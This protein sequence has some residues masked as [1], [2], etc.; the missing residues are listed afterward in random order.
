MLTTAPPHPRIA[1]KLDAYRRDVHVRR[2]LREF[3]GA[4]GED[5]PTARY[6]AVLRGTERPPVLWRRAAQVPAE[7]IDEVVAEGDV[8]RS[9]WDRESLVFLLDLDYQNVDHP[10]EPFTAPADVFLKLEPTYISVLRVFALYGL[11]AQVSMTGRGY[12]FVGRVPIDDLLVDRLAALLPEPPPWFA[13]HAL[14][15]AITARTARASAGLGVLTEFLAQEILAV[16]ERRSPIPVVLN[17]TVVG[18][19][20]S[21]R[22]CIS[23]DISHVGDPLDV[24][25]M[26]VP[27]S[28]YRW[29]QFRPDI[30][31]RGTGGGDLLVVVPR[32]DQTLAELMARGRDLD[33]AIALAPSSD[34][35]LPDMTRGLAQVCDAYE[36]SPLGLF[37]R[38]FHHE[39]AGA[40]PPPALSA[41]SLPPCVTLALRQPNDLLLRPEYLQHV[42]RGLI[43][44]GWAAR[45]VATLVAATYRE[46]HQWGD[47]WRFMDP[48]SRAEFDVRVFAGLIATGLDHLIDFNC[49]S[50]QEKGL[51]PGV[52]CTRDLRT[53]RDRLLRRIEGG[54]S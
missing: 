14:A 7:Q 44:R 19:G 51:C 52:V 46:D 54:L 21:G 27:F 30:F 25:H 43:A 50:S 53:E 37:H 36:G 16:A 48:A 23:I 49:V 39:P 6:L 8:S 31:G 32:T 12:H 4:S 13:G 35:T 47:H 5:A 1:D 11:P 2:R 26:R 9:L 17:G 40:T 41:T 22:E 28:T 24:R 42:T 34:T 10:W 38:R 3:C 45:Q 33:A 20:V 29:H 18:G 15:P